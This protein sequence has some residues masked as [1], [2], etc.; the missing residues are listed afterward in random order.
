MPAIAPPVVTPPTAPTQAPLRPRRT[1]LQQKQQHPPPSERAAGQQRDTMPPV[2]LPTSS[3]EKTSSQI[4]S[5][6][7]NKITK[8]KDTRRKNRDNPQFQPTTNGRRQHCVSSR[9]EK[10]RREESLTRIQKPTQQTLTISNPS[11]ALSRPQVAQH[12]L[13]EVLG[14][15]LLRGQISLPLKRDPPS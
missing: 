13:Q 14:K 9:V 6:E 11:S 2:M 5:P 8:A 12:D 4:G 3:P 10:R 1:K 15:H 7:F